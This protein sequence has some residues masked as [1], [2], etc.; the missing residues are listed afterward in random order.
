[1]GQIKVEDKFLELEFS[2]LPV[3]GLELIIE[4]F[5]PLEVLIQRFATGT[6]IGG[7]NDH[8]Q[9]SLLVLLIILTQ[10]SIPIYTQTILLIAFGKI[11]NDLFVD[12]LLVLLDLL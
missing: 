5:I 6:D 10:L 1:M 12:I 9:Q 3:L 7:V 2:L 8:L 11:L 4:P